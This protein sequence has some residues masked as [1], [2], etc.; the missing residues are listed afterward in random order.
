VTA[1]LAFRRNEAAI[2]RGSV[3]DKYLR[4]L[5]HIPEGSVFELGSAE[6]VL[7]LLLAREGRP[8]TALEKNRERHESALRLAASWQVKTLPAFINGGMQANLDLLPGHDVFLGVRSIYYLRDDLDTVFAEIAKH[9][10]N[11]T[12][13]GNQ[14]RARRY[15]QGNPDQPLGE[16]NYYAGA[17]GMK[18]LLTRHGYEIVEEVTEGD[19]IVVGKRV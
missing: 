4:L 13:C 1:S 7:A 19:A 10:P 5:P 18:D 8:V 9:I 17:E 16:F 11:V 14:G 15:H 3:P 6:G 2:I 12:L